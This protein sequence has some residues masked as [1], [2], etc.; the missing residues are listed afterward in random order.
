MTDQVTVQNATATN[1]QVPLNQQVHVSFMILDGEESKSF[2][3]LVQIYLAPAMLAQARYVDQMLLGQYHRFLINGY[4]G[5]NQLTGSN[6]RQ[7]ILGTRQIMNQNKAYL[8]GRNLIL[9]PASEA[10]MLNLDLFTAAYAVGDAGEALKKAYLGQKLGYDMFMAQN[11]V[12]VLPNAGTLPGLV[13]NV[14]GYAIGTTVLT[15]DGFTGAVAVGDWL[16]IAG[17]NF[18]HQVTAHSETLSNTTSITLDSGLRVAVLDD[19]VITDYQSGVT[20]NFSAGYTGGTGQTVGQTDALVTTGGSSTSCQ[21][22]QIVSFGTAINGTNPVYTVMGWDG[23]NLTLERPLEANVANSAVV[24][25][26]P[27]GS[28]NMAFHRNALALVVRPLSMPMA[29]AGALSAVI[30]HN[31][32]SMRVTITYLG[33]YQGHLVTLDMLCGIALLDQN[34][35]A[36]LLG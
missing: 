12:N 19:A 29:G 32:L 36:V 35:G 8:D 16:T 34:L 18:P 3:D 1:V 28:Y 22:G 10:S 20:I 6:A 31:S 2:K 15:V 7:Y 26:G 23:T 27:T 21:V 5:L 33:L 13:N 11:A 9:T 14:G 4:G 25:F 17:E 24:H 30:N